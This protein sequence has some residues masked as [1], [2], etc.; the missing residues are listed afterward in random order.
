LIDRLSAIT[1]ANDD[2]GP[3]RRSQLHHDAVNG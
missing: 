3:A 1:H 2:R